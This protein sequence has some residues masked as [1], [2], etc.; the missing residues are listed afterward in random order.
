MKRKPLIMTFGRLAEGYLAERI[1]WFRR[2]TLVEARDDG[3]DLL[4][5]YAWEGNGRSG[6][7]EA[8]FRLR[9]TPDALAVTRMW[10]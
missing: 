9:I 5:G 8:R 10:R 1:V 6:D 7:A 2:M 3:L 4:S